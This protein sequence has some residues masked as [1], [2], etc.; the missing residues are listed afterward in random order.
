VAPGEYSNIA[1]LPL[2]LSAVR[3]TCKKMIKSCQIA[4][5][6]QSGPGLTLQALQL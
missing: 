1:G 3:G 5:L 4:I 2:A 6:L